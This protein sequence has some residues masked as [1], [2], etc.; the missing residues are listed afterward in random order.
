[1]KKSLSQ[2]LFAF[3]V[4]GLISRGLKTPIGAILI[5]LFFI[6]YFIWLYMGMPGLE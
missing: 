5:P 4:A 3:A 2:W 1:M 6:A